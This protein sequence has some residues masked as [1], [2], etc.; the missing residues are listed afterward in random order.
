M[1]RKLSFLELE[2]SVNGIKK[3]EKSTK[4]F[5]KIEGML[6]KTKLKLGL[7]TMKLQKNKLKLI[8]SKFVFP[9][10][11]YQK[12]LKITK[13]LDKRYCNIYKQKPSKI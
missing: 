2:A 6:L 3:R 13:F 8:K 12:L 1:T 5:L 9:K 11:F 7:L 4:F 10:V